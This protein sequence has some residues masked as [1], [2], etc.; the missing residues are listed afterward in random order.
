MTSTLFSLI[1]QQLL[2]AVLLCNDVDVTGTLFVLLQP[3]MQL[4]GGAV[5]PAAGVCRWS[6]DGFSAAI[7]TLSASK[8]IYSDILVTGA[9]GAYDQWI[10]IL[11]C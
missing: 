11:G 8:Q 1:V 2:V 9:A 5:D 3:S 7:C 4:A 10:T 6:G